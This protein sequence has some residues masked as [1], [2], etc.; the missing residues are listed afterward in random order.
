MPH[1]VTVSGSR[2]PLRNGQNYVLGRGLDCDVVVEDAACSRRHAQLSVARMTGAAFLEDL[3]SR[4]GTYVNGDRVRSRVAVRDGSRLQV[5][6]SIFLVRMTEEKEEIEL[7]ETGTVAFEQSSFNQDCDGG[8]LSTYGVVEL[9]KLLFNARRSVSVHIAAEDASGLLEVRK[10]DLIFAEFQGL[11]GFNALVRLGRQRSG[12]FW[13]VETEEEC[14][15][16]ITD[17]TV[18]T[19]TEL[20]RCIDPNAVPRA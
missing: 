11:E 14:F 2:I 10:G 17:P 6:Q 3:G 9:I 20:Q 1:L 15:V 4:N 5:G 13:L 16:N 7:S 19:M 8:E 18:R 12:L